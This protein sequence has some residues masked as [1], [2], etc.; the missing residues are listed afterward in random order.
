[1][2][3]DG[4]QGDLSIFFRPQQI[5]DFAFSNPLPFLINHS[6]FLLSFSTQ[7]CIL[8]LSWKFNILN[9]FLSHPPLSLA[10]ARRMLSSS[11]SILIL[12]I[13][14]EESLCDWHT[15]IFVST[16]LTRSLNWKIHF[17]QRNVQ[18][19]QE[20]P[21]TLFQKVWS[22]FSDSFVCLYIFNKAWITKASREG[23]GRWWIEE[24]F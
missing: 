3:S 21:W 1:M 19:V 24:K 17:L 13:G 6:S 12:L 11:S 18:E 7:W 15:K 10:D 14:I 23:N 4:Y 2:F 22:K 16:F 5:Q 8:D 20:N 9:T